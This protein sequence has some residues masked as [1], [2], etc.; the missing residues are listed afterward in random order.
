MAAGKFNDLC[1]F[2]FRH[3]I[4]EDA[5]NTH[6]VTVD[7]QHHFHRILAVFGKEFLEDMNDEFH[8]RIIVIQQQHLVERRLFDLGARFCDDTGSGT[9]F[10]LTIPLAV[11]VARIFHLAAPMPNFS[12]D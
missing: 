3:L 10:A 1:H 12:T 9:V 2:C 4:G 5:A 7:M 11:I 8:R 6:T